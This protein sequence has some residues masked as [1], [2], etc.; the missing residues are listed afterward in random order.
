MFFDPLFI[1][2]TREFAITSNHGDASVYDPLASS[3]DQ[4]GNLKIM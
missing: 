1:L 2:F 4:T 3:P